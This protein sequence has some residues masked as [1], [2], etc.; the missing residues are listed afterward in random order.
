MKDGSDRGRQNIPFTRVMLNYQMGNGLE[1]LFK[2]NGTMLESVSE[3]QL[4]DKTYE[5]HRFCDEVTGGL[6]PDQMHKSLLRSFIGFRRYE[7]F[8]LPYF[9]DAF[10]QQIRGCEDGKIP[11]ERGAEG[12]KYDVVFWYKTAR[13]PRAVVEI[14][15][16]RNTP[17]VIEAN[18][19]L[20]NLKR[21]VAC[22]TL[23]YT[24]TRF[25]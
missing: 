25:M 16:I 4:L 17:S 15:A 19:K 3:E 10:A 9:I 23:F 18:K 2:V 24:S 14:K 22:Y 7:D 13:T 8:G 12:E 6:Y 20:L 11:M 21:N 5:A 1:E